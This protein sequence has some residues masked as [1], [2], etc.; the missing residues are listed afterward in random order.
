MTAYGE[1][2]DSI[3][4]TADV[5]ASIAVEDHG[6]AVPN[7]PGWSVGDVIRHVAW[8]GPRAWIALMEGDD[9]RAA[10]ASALH[11]RLPVRDALNEL[12]DHLDARDPARRCNSFFGE[13]T[14]GDWGVHCSVELALHRCDVRAALGQSAELST[15]EAR[16]GLLWS[17]AMLE[18]MVE[19]AG[20]DT[21]A[22]ISVEPRVGDPI[23]LG[24]GD[25]VAAASGNADDLVFWLWGRDRGGVEVTGDA[26]ATDGWASIS[27]R[28]F[29]HEAIR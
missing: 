9:W 20:T 19:F 24:S 10:G 1:Q 4:T 6:E 12:V 8:G 28:S 3:R 27:G 11:E 2:L 15:T 23:R 16:D 7:C 14:Y 25:P 29:Q 17:Q 22:P 18:P 5:L 13:G 26:T 21:P